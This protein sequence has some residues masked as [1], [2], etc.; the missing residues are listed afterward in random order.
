[1]SPF[2]T[3][4]N[5]GQTILVKLVIKR[6][7]LDGKMRSI[8]SGRGGS[9]C[10]SCNQSA[11]SYY[12]KISKYLSD[13]LV[14]NFRVELRLGLVENIFFWNIMCDRVALARFFLAILK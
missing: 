8:V 4:T 10:N 6:P 2:E 9:F 5:D 12:G 1:M 3:K 7:M 14:R 13:P 11:G